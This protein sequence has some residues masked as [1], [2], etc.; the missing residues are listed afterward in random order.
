MSLQT[1]AIIDNKEDLIGIF[2]VL[3]DLITAPAVLC[4]VDGS[5]LKMNT[6]A[7]KNLGF[8]ASRLDIRQSAENNQPDTSLSVLV[9]RIS[10]I[11]EKTLRG[12][13]VNQ[14]AYRFENA[15]IKQSAFTFYA[16]P[17]QK[18]SVTTAVLITWTKKSGPLERVGREEPGYFRTIGTLAAT[19]AHELRNPLGVIQ[20]AIYNVR[21]KNKQGNLQK[22]LDN[23]EN[24][25]EESERI[26]NN[27]LAYSRIKKPVMKKIHLYNF[28]TEC[29]TTFGAQHCGSGIKIKTELSGLS[30]VHF[31]LDPFQIREVLTNVLD[32][33]CG[34]LQNMAGEIIIKGEQVPPDMIVLS[35]SDNGEGIDSFD[36]DEVFRPFFTRK[37][38]GTGLGLT[39]SRELINLHG[40]TI[41]ISS[42]KGQ[43]TSVRI[44]LPNGKLSA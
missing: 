40:G 18:D 22:H 41:G 30:D 25:I 44:T 36:L 11:F 6:A 8:P 31:T 1:N 14:T 28:L 26:I 37:S 24:K 20:T 9:Q 15:K 38:K 33:A 39:I 13:A 34:A 5:I 23:I 17:V 4:G 2:T 32:N 43:G 12:T 35:V 16:V 29:I 42:Q 19:V 27:L 21:R 10:T 7:A 3:V